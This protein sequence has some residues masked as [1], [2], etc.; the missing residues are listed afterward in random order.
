MTIVRVHRH[1]GEELIHIPREEEVIQYRIS[2]GVLKLFLI[3]SLGQHW[4]MEIEQVQGLT[5]IILNYDFLH[6]S[7]CMRRLISDC[8]I[9][10]Q[11]L[12]QRH[13]LPK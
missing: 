13:Y 8:T 1:I 5:E 10:Y 7:T 4:R 2:D 12:C 6:Y 11:G 3:L 9:G